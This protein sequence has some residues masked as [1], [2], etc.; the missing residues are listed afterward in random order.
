MT[1]GL[2]EGDERTNRLGLLADFRPTRQDGFGKKDHMEPT[3]TDRNG[4]TDG[5]RAGRASRSC[6]TIPR[7]NEGTAF[8]FGHSDRR[9]RA[10]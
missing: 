8:D 6:P 1:W 9:V 3:A 5:E 7:M 4:L 2:K 10:G